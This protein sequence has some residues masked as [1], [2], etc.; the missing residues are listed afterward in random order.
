MF[1]SSLMG[2]RRFCYMLRCQAFIFLSP[3]ILCNL[4][5]VQKYQ[6]NLFWLKYQWEISL[7]SSGLF[8]FHDGVECKPFW[9]VYWINH[10]LSF[11]P[12]EIDWVWKERERESFELNIFHRINIRIH[13]N[14]LTFQLNSRWRC[15]RKIFG[16][17]SWIIYLLR[18]FVAR[19]INKHRLIKLHIRLITCCFVCENL[20]LNVIRMKLTEEST[21]S[22]FLAPY[23]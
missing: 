11:H 19:G 7:N 13:F 2:D 6:A 5:T 18:S 1:C 16:V 9:W 12:F 23:C 10:Q 21:L 8:P 3:N 17:F 4:E 14:I 22:S 15:M 20:F